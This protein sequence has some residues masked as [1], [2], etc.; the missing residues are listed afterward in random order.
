M[1]MV[2]NV[3]IVLSE[4]IVLLLHPREDVCTVWLLCNLSLGGQMCDSKNAAFL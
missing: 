4:N 3:K 1:A 2:G